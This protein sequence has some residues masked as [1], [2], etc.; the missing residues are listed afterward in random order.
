MIGYNTLGE[1][2][3]DGLSQAMYAQGVPGLSDYLAEVA[4]PLAAL[5]NRFEREMAPLQA[6]SK[7]ISL[8][9]APMANFQALSNDWAKAVATPAPF[10]TSATLLKAISQP[11]ALNIGHIGDF[12]KAI[13]NAASFSSV[14]QAAIRALAAPR[15]HLIKSRPLPAVRYESPPTLLR[16]SVPVKRPQQ[17]P[18]LPL[19]NSKLLPNEIA[20]SQLFFARLIAELKILPP[21]D[22][23]EV[24]DWQL[25]LCGEAG[26][27]RFLDRLA[28]YLADGKGFAA[29][30]WQI[31]RH[32]LDSVRGAAPQP[33]WSSVTTI[34]ATPKPDS[35][36]DKV[37]L[38]YTV[39][40][41]T[42]L[43]IDLGLLVDG[44]PAPAARSGTW[45]GVIHGLLDATP[46]RLLDNKAA[47]RRAFCEHFGAVV[48][49][50]AIQ[51]G[52]G[53]R[54]SVADRFRN[55]TLALL[56]KRTSAE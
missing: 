38:N 31:I 17:E 30:C 48:G 27:E 21:P 8:A 37:L 55:D 47:I 49:E 40:Q 34:N 22:I 32:W 14:G 51:D 11:T 26:R 46:P 53:K 9:A 12:A 18:Q 42:Q 29:I 45:V 43:L 24:L 36:L 28:H 56:R 35:P 3:S 25:Q 20:Q 16:P 6:M 41:L 54:D 50:R 2:L 19:A 4:K 33:V 10:T 1:S 15:S 7:Q 52:P 39:P 13:A 23:I 5:S 44:K